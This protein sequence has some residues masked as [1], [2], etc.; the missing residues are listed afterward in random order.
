MSRG[1]QQEGVW[2]SLAYS[3][4]FTRLERRKSLTMV[5]ASVR[6]FLHVAGALN[7]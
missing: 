6:G 2:A 4:P 1:A 3:L 7:D 5:H